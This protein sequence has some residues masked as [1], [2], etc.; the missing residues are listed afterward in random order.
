VNKKAVFLDRDGTLIEDAD[1]IADPADVRI[2]PGVAEVL[3]ELRRNGYLLVIIS[4]Q[5][6]IGRGIFTVD[7]M[8]LINEKMYELFR[9]ANVEFLD[10]FYCPHSPQEQ[11]NCRKPSP[12]LLLTAAEQYGIS[13]ADS[14]MIGDKVSDAEC[15]IAAGCHLN[16]FLDVGKQPAPR[17]KAGITVLTSMTEAGKLI[18]HS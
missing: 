2:I 11:C 8:R 9:N 14:V 1:Y 6:G 13:L 12:E 5:S 7:T 4:N 10:F 18:L 3:R 15:G 16:I 17:D